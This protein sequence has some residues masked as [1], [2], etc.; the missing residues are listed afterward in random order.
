MIYIN[1]LWV[2]IT[3]AVSFWV[4]VI[5]ARIFAGMN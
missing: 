3:V 4:G 5:F 2:P 1:A